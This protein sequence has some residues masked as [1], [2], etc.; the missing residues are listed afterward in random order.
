MTESVEK[1]SRGGSNGIHASCACDQGTVPNIPATSQRRAHVV[2]S[3][4]IPS[5]NTVNGSRA[6]D[7]T[8]AFRQR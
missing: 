3:G 1:S 7:P 4:F 2:N 5:F 6:S 8:P